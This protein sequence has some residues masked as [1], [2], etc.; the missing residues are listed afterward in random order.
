MHITGKRKECPLVADFFEMAGWDNHFLG[1]NMQIESI[2]KTVAERQA[3]VLALS[4][5]MTFHI[6]KVT[7]ISDCRRRYR[8]GIT[9]ANMEKLF[10]PLFTTKPKGIGLGLA[11]SKKN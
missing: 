8:P 1:A 10:E 5:T 7:G 11:V 9:S 2:I 4:I 3:N 6:D